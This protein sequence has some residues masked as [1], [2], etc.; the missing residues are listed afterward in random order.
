[1]L[2][3]GAGND[4]YFVDNV[5][6]QVNENAGA[7]LDTIY[8]TTH[9]RLPA[10]VENLVLQG[11]ADL[12]AYGNGLSNSVYG[13]AGSNLLDGGAG[14]DAMFGGAGNDVYFV[15]NAG[16]AVI[17]NAGEGADAVFSSAHFRLSADVET[18]VMQGSAD[19]QGYGNALA[20]AIYGNGGNNLIDGGGGADIMLG[21]AGSDAYFVDNAGDTVVE[22]ANEGSDTVFSTAHFG[23]SA[24]VETLVLQGSADLQGYGNG[25]ANSLFGNS[26]NNL[27]DGGAGADTM[28][29]GARQRHLFRRQC[30]ATRWSRT[31]AQ[32]ADA[33][34]ATVSYTLSRQRGDAG[35]AGSGDLTG[36]GNALANKILRQFRQQHAR[37][38][39]RRR[40][41]HRQRRQRHL[42]VQY[43]ARPATPSSDFDGKA[44]R[45]ETR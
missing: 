10:N 12:Q 39:R 41:A 42:R 20:N 29:G 32:G 5:G 33:V 28:A 34:F 6:D 30:R 24:N 35:A 19:L 9:F 13:N 4:A 1:M 16:D 22:N 27:L 17:E 38:R 18:L 45:Q 31:P 40:R 3:G 7:G 37:R 43:R 25:L 15:D 14:A 21:G 11:S 2:A 23:L 44:R 8:S 36:T 26:G